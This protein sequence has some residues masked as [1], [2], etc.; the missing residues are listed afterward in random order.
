M[1]LLSNKIFIKRFRN[2]GLVTFESFKKPSFSYEYSGKFKN[3]C[4]HEFKKLFKKGTQLTI[5]ATNY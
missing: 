4:I 1:S 2:Q 3:T 5:R